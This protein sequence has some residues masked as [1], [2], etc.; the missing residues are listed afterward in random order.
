[1]TDSVDYEVVRSIGPVQIRKYPPLTLATVTT[2]YDDVA[3]S[4]LFQYI[5][6]KNEPSE[7]IPM[8]S[9]VL[10][11]RPRGERI[12]MT[13]PVISDEGSFSFVLP[14][15][16]SYRSAPVPED[17]RIRITEVP[18]RYIAVV[19]F[20]GRAY[21]RDVMEMERALLSTLEKNHIHS[22][23][24]PFLMRYNSPFTPGFLRRNEVGVELHQEDIE[25][26]R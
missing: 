22:I 24:S 6:G 7:R 20:S 4:I 9:P 11:Q 14:T 12:A 21:D 1:M 10:S 25:G 3:F 16:Y 26:G 8:I 15:K 17:P 18:S 5:S 19:Q 13:A 2:S 23:G